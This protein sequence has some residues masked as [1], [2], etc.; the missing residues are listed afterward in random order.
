MSSGT[1]GKFEQIFV[2]NL[3]KNASLLRKTENGIEFSGK[4]LLKS[5][6]P[7]QVNFW[8]LT[9]VIISQWEGAEETNFGRGKRCSNLGREG[10]FHQEWLLHN[11][12]QL[13]PNW[14]RQL[15]PWNSEWGKELS[16]EDHPLVSRDWVW[17]RI[18]AQLT[19]TDSIWFGAKNR[20]RG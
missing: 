14:L 3:F 10:K 12:A 7:V 17:Q 6:I 9:S 8:L 5:P 1:W 15:W 2:F 13:K 20:D 11:W 19:T 18:S 4:K 16:F